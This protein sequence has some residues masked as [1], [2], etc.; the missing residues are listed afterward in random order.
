MV[1]Y[2]FT[3]VEIWLTNGDKIEGLWLTAG[4]RYI[5]VKTE[6]GT[7]FYIPYTSILFINSVEVRS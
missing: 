3:R 7:T 5:T 4:P 6:D 2:P 1:D